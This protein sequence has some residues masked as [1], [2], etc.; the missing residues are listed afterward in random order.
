MLCKAKEKIVKLN[1]NGKIY[2]LHCSPENLDD[3]AIGLAHIERL[4]PKFEYKVEDFE[5]PNVKIKPDVKFTMD[6]IERS[7][8]YLDV[9]DETRAHHIAALVGK[10][11]LIARVLDVSRHSAVVKVIGMGVKKNVNFSRVYLL[12]S[13]RISYDIAL[14]CLKAK[15]PLIVSKKAILDSALKLCLKTGLSVVSFM[16]GVV[17]GDAVECC[18][19][20]W[21]KRKENKC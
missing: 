1:I 17:I 21:W 7:L 4:E 11:G 18:N 19:S 2:E 14:K 13:S 5:I 8:E 9:R 16:S 15:I 20:G 10:N 6:E 12:I 3:L